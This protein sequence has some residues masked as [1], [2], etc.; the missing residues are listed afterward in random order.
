MI[1][2]G[3]LTKRQKD[4]LEYIK[5][6][7]AQKKY[8]PSIREIA[9]NFNLSSPATAHVHV[10]KLIEK[11]YFKRGKGSNH[12]LELQVPNEFEKGRDDIVVVPLLGKVTA[13]NPIEAI[14]IPDEVMSLPS[15][16]LPKKK[17][18]F[19]IKVEGDSMINVG[20]YDKDIV[21]VERGNTAKNGDIVV[22][23]DEEN[24]VTIK[25]YYKENDY[26]RLQPENDYMIPIILK[27][28]TILG[29]AIGLYRKF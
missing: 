7:S 8:P 11:G 29:K 2:E 24:Q 22:A 6:F 13:G 17:E 12:L 27:E 15:Y 28:V 18:V 10:K 5:K 4:I 21:I 25:T 23:M 1:K 20:I 9:A 19:T 14:E 26:I 16:L 3:K